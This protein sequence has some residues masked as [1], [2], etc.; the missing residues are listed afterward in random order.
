MPIIDVIEPGIRAAAKVT[1]SG[2][3]GVIGTV[4]TVASGAYQDAAERLDERIQLTCAAC[5]GFVEF[6]EAGD[7]ESEQVHILAE[8]LLAP[9]REA[10]VDTLVLGCTHYPLLARTI[11]D[12]MGREVVL[13]SSAD[14]TAF[15]VR[16]LVEPPARG[17]ADAWGARVP[18]QRRRDHLPRARDPLPGA[19]SRERRGAPVELT[20][21]GCSGSYG[22]PRGGACSGYLVRSGDT[23]LW[24]DCGNGTFAHLQQH[25]AVE[26]LTAVVITH[27]HPDH[28]VDVYGLHVLMKW[29]LHREGFP[30]Y[31]PEGL[32]QHLGA[33][34]GGDWGGALGVVVDQ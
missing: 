1:R 10:N 25:I 3:V 9:V 22:D 20:V 31:A 23:A 34:V 19:R 4:L 30:V 24:L 33:L 2:R 8:R 6:V 12:V 27:E 29:G 26:D 13:V 28:C 32:D 11:S 14:E 16:E 7:V 18:H 5:P 15:A 21:L 17:V